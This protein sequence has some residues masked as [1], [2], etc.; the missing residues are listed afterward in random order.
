[1]KGTIPSI[2]F[3]TYLLLEASPPKFFLWKLILWCIP[4]MNDICR[5]SQFKKQVLATQIKEVGLTCIS[6]IIQ[7][8]TRTWL[9]VNLEEYQSVLIDIENFLQCKGRA[10]TQLNKIKEIYLSLIFA[11]Q[12]PLKL[13]HTSE[14]QRGPPFVLC[15][16]KFL[17]DVNKGSTPFF[18]PT[19]RN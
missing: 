10:N 18:S 17:Y 9:K 7:V 15:L 16:Y 11:T 4:S 2:I 5:Y 6:I 14:R 13:S 8:E 19:K 12:V 3:A 1:M